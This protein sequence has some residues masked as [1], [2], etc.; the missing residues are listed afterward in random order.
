M[1]ARLEGAA[2]A[3][4]ELRGEL[5]EARRKLRELV[6]ADKAA[7]K[8]KKAEALASQAQ[9]CVLGRRRNGGGG[10]LS[11]CHQL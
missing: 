2:E 7:K 6:D 10:G 8:A 9:V 1:A 3:A 4:Q 11:Q 5:A